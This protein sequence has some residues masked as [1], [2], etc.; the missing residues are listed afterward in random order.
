VLGVLAERLSERNLG[1]YLAQGSPRAAPSQS[2]P[3]M[4][5]LPGI[6]RD[7]GHGGRPAGQGPREHATARVGYDA[8]SLPPV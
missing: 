2:R 1:T 5:V 4:T 3:D 7:S 8:P 6:V